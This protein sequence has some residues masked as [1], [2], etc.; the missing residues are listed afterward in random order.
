M[1]KPRQWMLD[2]VLITTVIGLGIVIASQFHRTPV[3]AQAT[4][5][6][7]LPPIPKGPTSYP[8]IPVQQPNGA[9]A[10]RPAGP[11]LSTDEVRQF[12]TSNSNPVGIKGVANTSL[13]RV[14]CNQTVGKVAPM[15]PG[16]SLGLPPDMQVCY[17]ELNGNFTVYTPPTAQAQRGA[18]LTYHTAFRVFD[19]KTGNLMVTGTLNQPLA[20]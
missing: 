4:S 8:A 20:Q 11:S 12:L 3:Q 1:N 10:I 18:A 7:K 2:I 13:S 17:V 14:D 5:K 6:L 19:A 16:K 9:P 15:L